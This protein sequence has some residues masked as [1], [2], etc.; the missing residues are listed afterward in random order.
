MELQGFIVPLNDMNERDSKKK[1][2]LTAERK[3]LSIHTAV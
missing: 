1:V 3:K 2:D